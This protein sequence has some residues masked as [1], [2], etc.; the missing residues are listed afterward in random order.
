MII[1]WDYSMKLQA[2]TM[3]FNGFSMEP[4]KFHGIP[5]NGPLVLPYALVM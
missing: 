4:R 5:H 3:E 2:K 1:E